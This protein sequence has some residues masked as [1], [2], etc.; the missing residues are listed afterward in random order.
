MPN[1][2][3]SLDDSVSFVKDQPSVLNHKDRKSNK[4]CNL[5]LSSGEIVNSAPKSNKFNRS[6]VSLDLMPDNDRRNSENVIT[7][8]SELR[9]KPKNQTSCPFLRR[10]GSCKKGSSCDFLHI[11]EPL[12]TMQQP[13]QNSLRHAPASH[14]PKPKF[15]NFPFPVTPHYFSPLRF[16]TY[17][18]MSL[19]F[20]Y[21]PPLM[22]LP[23]IPPEDYPLQRKF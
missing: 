17:Y 19:P 1:E 15:H 21:P 18:P 13:T 14:I 6:R 5:K 23:T 4:D 12:N 3:C 10:R 9:T 2:T 22:S 16:P 8:R 7:S 20:P 11:F